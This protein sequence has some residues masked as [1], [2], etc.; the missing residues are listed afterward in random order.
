MWETPGW[1]QGLAMRPRRLA[2]ALRACVC[3]PGRDLWELHGALARPAGVAL[4]SAAEVHGIVG[5]LWGAARTAPYVHPH[6]TAV[7]DDAYTQTLHARRRGLA[8]LALLG[9]GLDQARIPWAVLR[10]PILAE[11]VYRQPELRSYRDISVLV[12]PDAFS[13]AQRTIEA[14]GARM[15]DRDAALLRADRTGRVQLTL[16][17]GSVCNL[18]WHLLGRRGLRRAFRLPTDALLR[19]TRR[20][21]CG[22]IELA[23]LDPVDDFIH[24]ALDTCVSG[25][26]RLVRLKD[27]DETVRWAAPAWADVVKRCGE[28]GC[29]L[30][31]ASVLEVTRQTFHTPVPPGLIEELDPAGIWTRIVSLSRWLSPPVLTPGGGS[32]LVW[33]ARSTRPTLAASLRQLTLASITSQRPSSPPS[34]RADQWPGDGASRSVSPPYPEQRE[35]AAPLQ[36]VTY[37]H[38]EPAA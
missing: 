36:A 20:I 5:Y 4:V 8:D 23:A 1:G 26:D 32:A 6:V 9:R 14:A 35:Q 10:G 11:T 33:V 28:S 7:L 22:D 21:V 25:A 29:G 13:H 37:R 3:G 18:H 16:S 38:E 31:V 2:R 24:L 19:R 27:L 17:H 34:G 12:P 30:A 15:F